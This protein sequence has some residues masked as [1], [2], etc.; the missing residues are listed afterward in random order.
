MGRRQAVRQR[1]LVS[2][3]LGSNPSGPVF[4]ITLSTPQPLLVFDFDGVIVDGIYEYWWS[5]R[6][7]CLELLGRESNDASLPENVPDAFRQLRPW[8]HQGWEMVLLAAEL[9]RTTSPLF[10]LGATKF[11]ENYQ[12]NCKE[13]LEAWHWKPNQL[14][15]ALEKIRRQAIS[16]N[17]QHWLASHRVF[18]GVVQRLSQLNT[19]GY[20]FAVLT[21]KGAEF[22]TELLDHFQLKPNLL[23]GHEAGSKVNIL[24]QLST[25]HS[26]RGFIED[27]RSTLETIIDNSELTS[28]PCYLASWGY[29]KKADKKNLP[30]KI[31]LLD[32]K[33]FMAPLASWP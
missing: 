6:K 16:S 7:A 25:T 24:L 15:S 18:P 5:S 9:I 33:T 32:T 22:T 27:R 11:S 1:V 23:Y 8:V 21:T 10:I 12:L 29:L 26:I 13:A 2:P 30:P 28:L 3:F 31:H 4:L 14:Q 20:G 17:R 19:E